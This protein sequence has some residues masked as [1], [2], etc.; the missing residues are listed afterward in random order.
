[1]FGVMLPLIFSETVV[2]WLENEYINS[3]DHSE[4]ILIERMSKPIKESFLW[5]FENENDNI[6]YIHTNI[7]IHT[8]IYTH[9]HTHTHTL[10]ITMNKNIN[11]NIH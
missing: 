11:I 6:Q 4:Q 3:Q 10:K 7:H 5:V 2:K 1:M 9:T 8:Y